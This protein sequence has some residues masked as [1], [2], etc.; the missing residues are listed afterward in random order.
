MFLCLGSIPFPFPVLRTPA[1]APSTRLVPN[2]PLHPIPC[3]SCVHCR[4]IPGSLSTAS[5]PN[6]IFNSSCVFEFLRDSL[7]RSPRGNNSATKGARRPSSSA[8]V[9]CFPRGLTRR[10][11]SGRGWGCPCPRLPSI[12]P[13]KGPLP[14]TVRDEAGRAWD[15]WK[16]DA[17]E[18]S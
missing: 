11:T 10:L 3:P 7:S 13:R 2:P 6:R 12:R 4:S 15:G 1:A 8:V 17:M 16:Q 14:R 9:S 5:L 18:A